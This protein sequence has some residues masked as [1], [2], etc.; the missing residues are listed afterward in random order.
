MTTTLENPAY[1]T[2]RISQPMGI[3]AAIPKENHFFGGVFFVG[4]GWDVRTYI[5]MYGRTRKLLKAQKS[6]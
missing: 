1:M 4:G 5:R 2:H 6:C 3:E